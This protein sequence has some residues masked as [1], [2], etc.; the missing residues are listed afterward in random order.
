MLAAGRVSAAFGA[1]LPGRAHVLQRAQLEDLP[2]GRGILRSLVV[3]HAAEHAGE[4][5]GIP[6]SLAVL[7][8]GV[9][10]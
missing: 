2:L 10:R 8:A 4:S 6:L 5:K 7:P 1:P 3:A 9:E